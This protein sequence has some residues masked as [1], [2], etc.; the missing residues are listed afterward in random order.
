VLYKL[1]LLISD[2]VHFGGDCLS[3]FLTPSVFYVCRPI[4]KLTIVATIH[5]AAVM[6]I[7]SVSGALNELQLVALDVCILAVPQ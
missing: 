1:S 6:W 4:L 7:L 2:D 3:F 5:L